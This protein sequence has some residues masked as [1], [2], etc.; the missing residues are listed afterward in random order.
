VR[1]CRQD[2]TP[3]LWCG[4]SAPL[5]GIAA[6]EPAPNR[7]RTLAA[8][9]IAGHVAATLLVAGATV[10]LQVLGHLLNTRF[11][12][13][14]DVLSQ[15]LVAEPLLL[16]LLGTLGIIEFGTGLG[17]LRWR[18][19]A[20]PRFAV[21]ASVGLLVVIWSSLFASLRI[22]MKPFAQPFPGDGHELLLAMLHWTR[23]SW[24]ACCRS[25][26]GKP[27]IAPSP[28][29]TRPLPLDLSLHPRALGCLT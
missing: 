8:V 22:A 12:A 3:D 29:A 1:P 6:V 15:V 23:L 10:L 18:P 17:L 24:L 20:I 4:H 19:A 9:C 27:P 7:T 11:G 21:L 13:S 26:A 16:V 28:R 14:Q 5:L 2:S 25:S